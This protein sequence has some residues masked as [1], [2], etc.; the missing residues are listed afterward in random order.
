M[1][2]CCKFK[3]AFRSA[4]YSIS[5]AYFGSGNDLKH[6]TQMIVEDGRTS[7]CHWVT[8][9]EAVI[10]EGILRSQFRRNGDVEYSV[11]DP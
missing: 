1:P 2:R 8:C 3:V 6:E 5:L 9:A 10:V 11:A 7:L 4:R